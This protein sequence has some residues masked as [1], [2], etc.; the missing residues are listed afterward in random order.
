MELLRLGFAS[1]FRR[2]SI[3]FNFGLKR[4]ASRMFLLPEQRR[5]SGGGIQ[6]C[7]EQQQEQTQIQPLK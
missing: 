2:G 3:H 5:A 4:F 1:C 7:E 6:T